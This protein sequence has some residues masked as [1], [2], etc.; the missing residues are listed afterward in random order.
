MSDFVLQGGGKLIDIP[1]GDVDGHAVFEEM[2]RGCCRPRR[3]GF[4]AAVPEPRWDRIFAETDA[5]SH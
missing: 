1:G 3:D 2:E 5:R 4:A